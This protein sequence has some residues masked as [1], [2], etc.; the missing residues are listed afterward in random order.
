MA[1]QQGKSTAADDETPKE[2]VT[3][4]EKNYVVPEEHSKCA[5]KIKCIAAIVHAFT[6]Y[7]PI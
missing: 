6:R 5:M 3:E 2:T 7:S 1:T 4:E